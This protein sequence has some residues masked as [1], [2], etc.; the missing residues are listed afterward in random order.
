MVVFG[1]EGQ[2]YV[3]PTYVS[4]DCVL[5]CRNLWLTNFWG[6]IF[7]FSA[8]FYSIRYHLVQFSTIWYHFVFFGLDFCLPK[9]VRLFQAK[10]FFRDPQIL[11]NEFIGPKFFGGPS[12]SSNRKFLW[13][14][15]FFQTQYLFGNGRLA[16][17]D[18]QIILRLLGIW[19]VY[20]K[21]TDKCS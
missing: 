21:P 1:V 10:K 7:I 6:N 14:L 20:R 18:L 11:T 4:H 2:G 5:R 13:A 8:T 19:S 12:T 15:N 16:L 3:T 17:A 9:F